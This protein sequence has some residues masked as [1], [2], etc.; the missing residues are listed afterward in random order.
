MLTFASAYKIA[1]PALA[2]LCIVSLMQVARGQDASYY[3]RPVPEPKDFGTILFS[4]GPTKASGD[5][6]KTDYRNGQ[7]GFVEVG[8]SGSVSYLSPSFGGFGFVV[9]GIGVVNPVDK[10]M[11]RVALEDQLLDG[12]T[13]ITSISNADMGTWSHFGGLAGVNLSLPADRLTFEVRALGGIVKHTRPDF[14]FDY[15]AV[16]PEAQ[17]FNG[18]LSLV[19]NSAAALAMQLEAGFRYKFSTGAALGI[20]AGYLSSKPDHGISTASEERMRTAIPDPILIPVKSTQKPSISMLYL[21]FGVGV[22]LGT[23]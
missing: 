4:F 15:T 23:K 5:L 3:F 20:T 22:N 1:F 6:G 12:S 18:R 13:N 21:N 10:G 9:R 14:S 8:F 2:V 16:T 19:G 7:S 11:L 17:P